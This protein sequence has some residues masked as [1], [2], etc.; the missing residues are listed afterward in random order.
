VF[1]KTNITT[2][3]PIIFNDNLPKTDDEENDD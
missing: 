3:V 1:E 2:I